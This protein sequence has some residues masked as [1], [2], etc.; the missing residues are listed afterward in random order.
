MKIESGTRR[1]FT[2]NIINHK[3]Q[4]NLNISFS[5]SFQ[6]NFFSNSLLKPFTLHKLPCIAHVCLWVFNVL[7]WNIQVYSQIIMESS[8]N[9]ICLYTEFTATVSFSSFWFDKVFHHK[10]SLFD[11]WKTQW[12]FSLQLDI[13]TVVT[14]RKCN[15]SKT[16]VF[17]LFFSHEYYPN[18]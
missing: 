7:Y 2:E 3:Q 4:V 12:V 6:T 5:T 11:I 10:S 9:K 17:S 14:K 15:N 13:V 16:H 8:I 18:M 1:Q